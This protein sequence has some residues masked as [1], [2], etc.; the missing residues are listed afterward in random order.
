ML[1]GDIEE[2]DGDMLTDIASENGISVEW[3]FEEHDDD[4]E[5][6]EGID[7]I[8]ATG[9]SPYVQLMLDEFNRLVAIQRQ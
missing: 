7:V 6:Q 1:D 8:E 3:T 5:I 4:F 2:L 9:K